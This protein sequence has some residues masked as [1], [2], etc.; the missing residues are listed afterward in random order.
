MEEN[1]INENELEQIS[2]GE[3]LS[4][5]RGN[6]TNP[7]EGDTCYFM[8]EVV[9]IPGHEPLRIKCVRPIC[10]KQVGGTWYSCKCLN[11]TKCID[12]LHLSSGCE[13]SLDGEG[14]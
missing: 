7:L 9:I 6:F 8:G 1:R 14:E 5:R 13:D 3:G 4:G 2:G 12:K 11:T 10:A